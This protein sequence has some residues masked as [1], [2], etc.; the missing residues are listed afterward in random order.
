M[1]EPHILARTGLSV[2]EHQERTIASYPELRALA[3]HL[4]FIPVVQG[5]QL[6]DHLRCAH[7]FQ[8]PSYCF[9]GSQDYFCLA[10]KPD[11][12]SRGPATARA[13]PLRTMLIR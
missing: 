4:P 7:L 9:S 1:C 3:P 10:E 6:A 5:W 11:L 2:R 8:R 13:C 12:V